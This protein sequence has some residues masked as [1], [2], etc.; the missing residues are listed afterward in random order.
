MLLCYF[1]GLFR[2]YFQNNKKLHLLY[3]TVAVLFVLFAIK[4][5]LGSARTLLGA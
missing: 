2:P 1:F 4:L 5:A 3:R